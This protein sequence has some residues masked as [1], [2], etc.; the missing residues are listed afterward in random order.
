M[1]HS[2]HFL[3]ACVLF[4]LAP[5]WAEEAIET[6][7]PNTGAPALESMTAGNQLV[8]IFQTVGAK[9]D[10]PKVEPKQKS[11]DARVVDGVP[12]GG[13]SYTVMSSAYCLRGRTASGR[14]TRHGIVAVDPRLIPLGSK[15]YVPGYG[16]AIAADT[17]GAII[18]H[19]IDI[20]LP[21]SGQCY[22]WGIRPV[23]IKVFPR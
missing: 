1:K 22:Q 6:V 5:A 14:Y 8:D 11:A 10:M 12:E 21:S 2:F 20:W 16:W 3:L 15:L 18:G 4:C 17:G 23:T 9:I 7:V 13:R 19:R